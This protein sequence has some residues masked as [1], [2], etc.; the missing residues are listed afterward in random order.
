MSFAP[1]AD[2]SF[3]DANFDDANPTWSPARDVS[4]SDASFESDGAASES[5]EL[6]RVSE[7]S[8]A[9]FAVLERLAF[10]HGESAESYRGAEPDRPCIL[11]A[12]GRG[13]VSVILG[14]PSSHMGGGILAAADCRLQ[15]IIDLA[16]FARRTG[17]SIAC[18]GI[19]ERD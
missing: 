11:P 19:C 8:R 6:R 14:G 9:D 12:N 5:F 2:A 3:D 18:Y 17:R 10:E 13:A 16:D 7:L 15:M 1:L 4:S